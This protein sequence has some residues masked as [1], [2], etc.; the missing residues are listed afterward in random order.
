MY[1]VCRAQS[2]DIPGIS[3]A[4][5]GIDRPVTW[6]CTPALRYQALLMRP[7]AG[8]IR[9]TLSVTEKGKGSI[10]QLFMRWLAGKFNLE[11]RGI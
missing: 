10:L 1:D 7:V 6:V 9:G 11:N 4:G 5:D 3:G 8:V 2:S